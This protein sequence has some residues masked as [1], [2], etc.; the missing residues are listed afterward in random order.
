[1]LINIKLNKDLTVELKE[2]SDDGVVN[3]FRGENLISF[4]NCDIWDLKGNFF[5]ESG[6]STFYGD[7]KFNLKNIWLINHY[8]NSVINMKQVSSHQMDKNDNE[9]EVTFCRDHNSAT[10]QDEI[11]LLCKYNSKHGDY[12]VAICDNRKSLGFASM[13]NWSIRFEFEM[14]SSN[15]E[16][17][18]VIDPNKHGEESNTDLITEYTRRIYN[19][20]MGLDGPRSLFFKSLSVLEQDIASTVTNGKP[21]KTPKLNI[22]IKLLQSMFGEV[23]LW[24]NDQ[25]KLA[26][27]AL[28]GD[29]DKISKNQFSNVILR[30]H[31]SFIDTGTHSITRLT[32]KQAQVVKLLVDIMVILEISNP[33]MEE[34]ADKCGIRD[35]QVMKERVKRNQKE[36]DEAL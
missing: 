22:Y 31:T 29:E 3:H 12:R 11:S 26:R 1:M 10:I 14:K 6:F 17:T 9:Y 16:D 30:L 20:P 18:V 24:N 36:I 8:D 2:K 33:I 32:E 23:K 15:E 25:K 13:D 5:S 28:I 21:I 7:D 27:K 35:L 19:E 4:G 34:L